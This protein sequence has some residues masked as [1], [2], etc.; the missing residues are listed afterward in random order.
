MA[1]YSKAQVRSFARVQGNH[2]QKDIRLS[3]LSVYP[4][5]RVLL[6][7]MHL[8]KSRLATRDFWIR[9][10]VGATPYVYLDEL[11]DRRFGAVKRVKEERSGCKKMFLDE[12]SVLLRISHPNLVALLGFC[13]DKGKLNT[14]KYFVFIRY[15]LLLLS[16]C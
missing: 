1:V 3:S 9:I 13:M 4:L 8:R 12:V 16:F 7:L 2:D 11:G 14:N 10:G 5:P 15:I 6:E